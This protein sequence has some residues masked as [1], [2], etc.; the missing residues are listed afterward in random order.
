MVDAC[1]LVNVHKHKHVNTPPIQASGSTQI[2]FIFMSSAAAEFIF[3]CGILDVNTLFWSDHRP[4]YIDI[5][6]LR[7]L[8]YPVHGT[9]LAMERD[10]KL[11][12]PRIIDTYQSTLIQQL[13]NHNVGPRVDFLYIADPSAWAPHRESRFNAI[14]NDVERAMHCAANN[15]RHKYFKNNTWTAT[16]TRIIYQI[17]FWRLQRRIIE[18]GSQCGQQQTVS[19]YA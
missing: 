2:D 16:F 13:H 9:I 18:N 5:D 8:S 19:F 10:L 15:C 12:E 14:D 4:L 7:L 1:D 17:R 11:N 3:R 6:V